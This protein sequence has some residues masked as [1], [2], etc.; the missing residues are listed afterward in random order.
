MRP[1][2]PR[3][4]EALQRSHVLAVRAELLVDGAVRGELQVDDGTVTL[5]QTSASRGRCEVTLTDVANLVPTTPADPLAPYGN[6]IRLSRGVDF[7]DDGAEL[8]P[9]GVFRLEV[10]D[11]ADSGPDLTLRVSALDRSARMSD[12]RFEEPHQV[13]AGTDVADAILACLRAAWPAVPVGTWPATTSN[14]PTL[15]G[16]EGG[17]RW[18]FCLKLA[19]SIGHELYFDGDGALTL[20]PSSVLSSG[21]AEFDLAEGAD[22]LLIS[23]G[24]KWSRQGAFNR[25][26]ATSSNAAADAAP[27]RGVATDDNPNSP[28]YYFGSFGR[29][30]RF[31]S[32]PM[33]ATDAQAQDA[34]TAMLARELG[35][36]QS[37]NF[38]AVVLPHLEPGD[39]VRIK[40]ARVG[41]AVED[42]VVDSLTIPLSATGTMTGATRAVQVT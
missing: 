24:R 9:L 17:D 13:A 5:D 36:T 32:S 27:A 40:R 14:A 21:A 30:P 19:E 10:V 42:H 39:V 22:G 33:L 12:A 37:V 34:A 20:V 1:A 29:V 41:L 2:S 16:E 28:T 4:A 8:V 31:Y 38:G 35:T 6:E 25:V 23:A 3:L 18:D 7:G 26:I 15:V 11:V